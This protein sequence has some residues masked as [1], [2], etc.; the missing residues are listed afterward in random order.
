MDDQA[1]GA[2]LDAG[3]RYAPALALN[4]DPAT[5]VELVQ[6]AWVAVLRAGPRQRPALRR[7][8]APDTLPRSRRA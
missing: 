1:V 2:L 7:F 6:D 5:A 4:H 3:Y 8:R